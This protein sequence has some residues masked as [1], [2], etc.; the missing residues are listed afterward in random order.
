MPNPRLAARYAKSLL[1]LA[2]EQ[3]QVE[4]VC[5]DMRLMASICKTNTD[6]TNMLR[7]PV[8]K[9]DK[10]GSIITAVLGNKI[11]ALTTAFNKL[12]VQKGRESNLPEIA[13]AFIAQYNE[14]NNIAQVKITTAVPVS[15]A[16]VEAMMNKVKLAY[17]GKK[18]EV[19][20]RVDESL[21]GGFLLETGGNL[22]D[23]SVAKELRGVARQFMRNDYILSIR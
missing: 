1:D 6:F 5:S 20:T 9:A 7:S 17:P 8:I 15:T 4:A 11:G 3:N 16:T 23:T 21:I 2:K 18:F 19:E 14:L 13:A 22:V 12:L 10:K